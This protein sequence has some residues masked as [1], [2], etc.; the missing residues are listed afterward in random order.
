[1]RPSYASR[2]LLEQLETRRLFAG[3]P[4]AGYALPVTFDFNRSKPGLVDRDGTGIGFTY[5]QPNRTG[6][7]YQPRLIDE[8]VGAGILR[9]YTTGTANAGS[10][11][12]GDNTLVNALAT[13][14]AASSKPW[15]I[16]TRILGPLTEIT[17]PE[18]EGGILFGPDEDNYV[19][20]VVSASG[21]KTG[22]QFF[23]EQKFSTGYKHSLPMTVYNIGTLS[24]ITTL[25]L[26]LAGDPKTGYMHGALP[27]QR[28]DGRRAAAISSS[29]RTT[30]APPSSPGRRTAGSWRS[31]RT[32]P[33]GST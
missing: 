5:V 19:K 18:E 13:T 28:R 3:D 20:L 33:A 22:L 26:Y 11:F 21:G 17:Q 10:N 15:V 30:S 9:L 25:D 4:T 16:S 2:P 1:M 12:E 32:T 23:D 24:T 27:N 14:F 31:K 7:E 6:D 29:S 8:K